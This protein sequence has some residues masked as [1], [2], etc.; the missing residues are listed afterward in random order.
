MNG[1]FDAEAFAR[2]TVKSIETGDA[3]ASVL[4][5]RV[6]RLEEIVAARWPRRWFLRRKLAREI[7]ASVAIW[8]PGYIDP[9]N[10][11]GRRIS[12]ASDQADEI[13]DRQ[14][15]AREQGWPEPD[16]QDRGEDGW[17]PGT[18]FLS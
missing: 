18:G 14:A 1:P 3:Y 7:R 4:E 9:G 13:L 6:I 15:R 8:D 11:H 10:F 12:W 5:R 17:A 2:E 16:G